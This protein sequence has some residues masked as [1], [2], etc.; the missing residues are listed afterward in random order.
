[1]RLGNISKALTIRVARPYDD[2][3]SPR[4]K[5]GGYASVSSGHLS[6]IAG[7]TYI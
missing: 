3:I 2:A 5:P 1:M 6:S 4:C 7:I